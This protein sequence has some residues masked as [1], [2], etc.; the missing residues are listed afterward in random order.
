MFLGSYTTHEQ[1]KSGQGE[2]A[3]AFFT[4]GESVSGK[5][6][7]VLALG[8]E[9]GGSSRFVEAATG[10]PIQVVELLLAASRFGLR[11]PF[12]LRCQRR[13]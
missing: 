6:I 10:Q 5:G 3:S 1:K 2:L 11:G 12:S 4:P 9:T 13:G 7:D 8:H